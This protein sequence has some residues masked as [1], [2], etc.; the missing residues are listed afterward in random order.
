M[1]LQHYKFNEIL[2]IFFCFMFHGKIFTVFLI[3]IFHGRYLDCFFG[4]R[5]MSENQNEMQIS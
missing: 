5:D 3:D 4:G 1:Q 2:R